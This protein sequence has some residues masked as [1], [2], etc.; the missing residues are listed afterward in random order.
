MFRVHSIVSNIRSPVIA[1]GLIVVATWSGCSSHE[2]AD[3]A[4]TLGTSKPPQIESVKIRQ[5]DQ[6]VQASAETEAPVVES[7]RTEQPRD[8]FLGAPPN[9]IPQRTIRLLIPHQT[10]VRTTPRNAVR[11]SFDDLDLLKILN[12]DPVPVDAE[13]YLPDWLK[14]LHEQT[15]RI[16]G[17]M[18]PGPLAEDIPQFM[19]VRDAGLCCFGANPKV[20]DKIGVTLKEGTTTNY[21]AGRPFDVVGTLSIAGDEDDGKLRWLYMLND[22]EVIQ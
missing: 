12:M 20:Y 17:W 9:P 2:A 7:P 1:M 18:V 19:L 22:A 5:P 10:F 16:R 8:P 14:G 6:I 4:K 11:V 21:I 15:I 3:R 13:R